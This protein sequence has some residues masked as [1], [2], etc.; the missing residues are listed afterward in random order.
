M[1]Q[2]VGILLISWLVLW[3]FDKS[4]LNVL[5]FQP[6]KDRTLLFLKL[7]IVSS[8]CSASAYL[9]KMW[10]IEEQYILSPGLSYK[11]I[12]FGIWEQIRSVLTEELLC[13]GAL[14]YILIKKL[15]SKWAVIISATFF[16]LLHWLNAGVWGNLLQMALLF[17]FTFCMGLVLAY[18]FVKS[19]SIL[20]P[21]AIHFGWNLTQN[22]IFPDQ[23]TGTHIFMLK[24]PA[25]EVTV[26][27]LVFF[28]LLLL[29]KISVLVINY[30]MLRKVETPLS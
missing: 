6:T 18:S 12:L 2:L 23:H 11:S 15:G 10:F 8:I 22:F 19:N 28:T 30:F 27:Y 13:R 1:I 17:I 5:G 20:I 14:L 29:P 26:S 4:N 7:F 9:L 21:F 24:T 16:A 25:P 3:L